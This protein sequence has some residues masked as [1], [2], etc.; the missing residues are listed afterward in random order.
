MQENTGKSTVKLQDYLSTVQKIKEIRLKHKALTDSPNSLLAREHEQDSKEEEEHSLTLTQNSSSESYQDEDDEPATNSVD[1]RMP[2]TAGES[3][4]E[5]AGNMSLVVEEPR[6]NTNIGKEYQLNSSSPS[7]V[8]RVE[9][10]VDELNGRFS[11]E[12]F[13]QAFDSDE[14]RELLDKMDLT[15]VEF[16]SDDDDED[17]FDEEGLIPLNVRKLHVV[18]EDIGFT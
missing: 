10:S 12:I 7:L 4:F 16:E 1:D 11:A 9:P 13:H 6:I 8:E 3:S 5:E 14:Q 18:I 2:E 17:N 15:D